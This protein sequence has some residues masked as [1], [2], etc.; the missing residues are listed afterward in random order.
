MMTKDHDR[1]NSD[2]ENTELIER[3]ELENSPFTIITTDEGSF[4]A[5]G[6][7]RITEPGEKSDIEKELNEIT[8]N[9]IV[10]VMLILIETKPNFKDEN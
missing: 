5:M 4:G 9:R 3:F 7:Y 10:Q 1:Q 8:W 2:S 6:K